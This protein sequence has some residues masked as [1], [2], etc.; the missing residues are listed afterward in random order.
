[1]MV[2]SA[3][4]I[5]MVRVG[6]TRPP[7]FTLFTITYKVAFY[8]PAERADTLPVFHLYPICTPG[9]GTTEYTELQ[10]PLS[11]AHS[12]MLLNQPHPGEGEGAR[13]PPFTLSNI[14]SKDVVYAP[15]S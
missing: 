1:M 3:S 15:C 8:A 7:P 4:A 11:G 12:I 14:T 10:W 5:S 13:H 6:G 9:C 2:K